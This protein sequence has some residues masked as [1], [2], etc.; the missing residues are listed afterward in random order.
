[1]LAT[2][3]RSLSRKTRRHLE[4]PGLSWYKSEWMTTGTDPD[5]SP[6]V[7]MIEQD[8]NTVL[9]A[10][11]HRQN[12]YQVFV[13]G[14]GQIGSHRVEP[15]TVHYAGAYTGY[16]PL[17]A[18]PR[19]LKYFTI[20]PVFET[21]AVLLRDAK[22]EMRKGPKRGA[23][24]RI[25]PPGSTCLN[26]L[27]EVQTCVSLAP[28]EDGL[29]IFSVLY[30]PGERL[31][32][33]LCEGSQGFFMLITEGAAKN[34]TIELQ[35]WDSLFATSAEELPELRA[36]EGGAAGLWLFVPPKHPQYS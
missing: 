4:A 36:A 7:F 24:V 28:Q 8:A 32:P 21:G 12:Q 13:E 26:A 34:E 19:G 15:I 29:G 9:P 27:S 33:P 14:Y 35:K 30:P 20:R 23:Q 31:E 1:M 10:H 3:S 11:F 16:G 6:T 25:A 22:T 17:V 18:G 5:L 2:G